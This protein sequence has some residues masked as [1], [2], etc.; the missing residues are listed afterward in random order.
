MTDR[1]DF[2]RRRFAALAGGSALALAARP[3]WADYAGLPRTFL[4]NPGFNDMV[5]TAKYKKPGPYTIGFANASQADLWLV[6][7]THGVEFAAA[8]NKDRIKKLIMT[9]ANGDAAKQVS[10]IQDLMNQGID[11]L[12]V[13]PAA[14]DPL[15]PIMARAMKQG[16]PVVSVARRPKNDSSFVSFVTASDQALAR[17]SATWLAEKLGGKGSIVLLPGLAGASPAEMRLQA[18]K[19]V[20]AQYPDLKILDTQY[21]GWSPANGKKLMSA[22]IQRH[23][24]AITGVWA[25]SGLQGSGAVEAFLGAGAKPS[26]IPPMTGGDL[27]RMYKL[28]MENKFPFCGIDYTP[29][30]G[31]AAMDVVLDVLQGKSVPK[32]LDVTFQIVI[33]EGDETRSVKADVALK[34][35]V[36]MDA[37]DDL[38]MGHGMGPTYDP[39]TF[40]V[41]LPKG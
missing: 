12:L 36:R 7:F 29:S 9:D 23:G 37:A 16:I 22:L 3:A 21:T 39:K 33:S 4:W 34:D 2:T 26:E 32:R 27:N 28:A 20:F 25:D 41:E 5:D 1:I 13:N 40:K 18:A 17:I 11:L 31:I 35:Y 15:D 30:I 6:T 14:A 8:K 19:E 10:D 24:K 38:I